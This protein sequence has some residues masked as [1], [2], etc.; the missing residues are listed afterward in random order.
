[1]RKPQGDENTRRLTVQKVLIE[2]KNK[3]HRFKQ[4]MRNTQLSNDKD[5][6]IIFRRPRCP[7]EKF[8]DPS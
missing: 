4:C 5:S 7:T 6:K 2:L 1:M 8:K 3:V